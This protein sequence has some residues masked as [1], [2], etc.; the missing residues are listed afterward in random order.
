[1]KRSVSSPPNGAARATEVIVR[2]VRSH[3]RDTSLRTTSDT[4]ARK[5]ERAWS[6]RTTAGDADESDDWYGSAFD[7]VS[8]DSRDFELADDELDNNRGAAN[9]DQWVDDIEAARAELAADQRAAAAA[10]DAERKAAIADMKRLDR[11]SGLRREKGWLRV[12]AAVEVAKVDADKRGRS[13]LEKGIDDLTAHHVWWLVLAI[14]HGAL[15]I[16][17]FLRAGTPDALHADTIALSSL[18]VSAVVRNPEFNSA[19]YYATRLMFFWPAFMHPAKRWALLALHHQGGIHT[20]LGMASMFWLVVYAVVQV[21]PT[22]DPALQGTAYLGAI[23]LVLMGVA[24]NRQV[25]RLHHALFEITH[26]VGLWSTIVLVFVHQSLALG[27][28]LFLAANFYL[29]VG[30]LLLAAYPWFMTRRC[31]IA[32]VNATK[33]HLILTLIGW[34]P[35]HGFVRVA[36]SWLEFEWHA[37]ALAHVDKRARTFDLVITRAG[38]WTGDLI[39]RY[40][41]RPLEAP[42]SLLVRFPSQGVAAS[43]VAYGKV[44]VV[45]TGGGA[46]PAIC[47][48]QQVLISGPQRAAFTPT[49]YRTAVHLYWIVSRPREVFGKKYWQLATNYT[50]SRIHDTAMY[51]R[52]DITTIKRHAERL[53]VEAVFVLS[54]ETFTVRVLKLF[55]GSKIH[56]FGATFDS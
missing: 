38:D 8:D 29:M 28:S 7:E 14:I 13:V 16:V 17:Y 23:I 46:A 20:G 24:A 45:A 51:G 1:M 6:G 19:M 18:L 10:A 22:D 47:Y 55:K 44:L 37:F 53:G 54:N 5:L 11:K 42:R 50:T 12:N 40:C 4:S 2:R 9:P 41:D 34:A 52:P 49:V 31:E 27:N 25:R 48:S 36:R 32:S 15:A 39:D 21:A 3:K 30:V 35:H 43:L 33:N 26:R 56:A